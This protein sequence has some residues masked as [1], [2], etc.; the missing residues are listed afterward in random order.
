MPRTSVGLLM[1]RRPAGGGVE[2]FLVHP[3]GP[4]FANK[5]AGVW[6]VPK[7]EPSADESLRD[8]ALREFAEETGWAFEE[9]RRGDLLPLGAVRQKGGKVVHAWAFEGEPPDRPLVSGTYRLQWPPGTWRTYPEVDRGA[10]FGLPEAREKINP[11]QAAFL[12]RLVEA[13]AD[14]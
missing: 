6:T 13:L 7:G 14:Q 8:A 11:A 2:V 10:F 9:C 3:G 12:D 4:F 5:D 1:F